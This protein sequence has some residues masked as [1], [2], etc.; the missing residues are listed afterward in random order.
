MKCCHLGETHA[1]S[2]RVLQ[3]VRRRHPQRHGGVHQARTV[4]V[5]RKAV[6][7]GQ[8]SHLWGGGCTMRMSRR[9]LLTKTAAL[10]S[11]TTTTKWAHTPLAGSGAA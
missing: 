5:H 7:V 1:D 11:A 6:F 9:G 8:R 4:H 2:V 10:T 3:Y